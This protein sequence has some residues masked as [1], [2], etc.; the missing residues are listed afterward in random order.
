MLKRDNLFPYLIVSIFLHITVYFLFRSK[1]NPVFLSSPT[2]VSFY[3]LS[4]QRVEQLP[5]AV[6]SKKAEATASVVWEQIKS[7][8]IK[9]DVF[10]KK[11]KS[12]DKKADGLKP[13]EKSKDQIET[14]TRKSGE[15]SAE[16]IGGKKAESAGFLGNN[17]NVETFQALDFDKLTVGAVSWHEGLSFD[18]KNFNYPY[19]SEQIIRKI[20]GQ[21]R[22]DGNYGKLRVLVYF[23]IRRNGTVYDISVRESS[24]IGEYD[25]HALDTICRAAPFPDLPDGYEGDLLGVFFEFKCGN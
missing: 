14:D 25:K 17:G 5:A 11:K 18:A 21:W 23:K 6:S 19:Y 9:E 2:E 22:W 7:N 1:E 10:V 8:D 15:Q 24:G 16:A 20:W 4:S 12:P 3:S 13:D